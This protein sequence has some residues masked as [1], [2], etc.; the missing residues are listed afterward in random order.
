[1]HLQ[2]IYQIIN[3]EIW[4]SLSNIDNYPHI[5]CYPIK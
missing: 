4:K 3:A 5:M 2:D 1:M